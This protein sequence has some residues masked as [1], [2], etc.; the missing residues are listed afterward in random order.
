MKVLSVDDNTAFN[1]DMAA[2]LG[3][4][5]FDAEVAGS[6]EK[7]LSIIESGYQPDIVL[8]DIDL[9]KGRLDGAETA[10]IL[11][12]KYGIPVVF[13]SGHTDRDI[14]GK[15]RDAPGY[16]CIQKSFNN[17]YFIIENLRR[18]YRLHRRQRSRT[19]LWREGHRYRR[20]YLAAPVLFL[21][22]E[23]DHLI[24]SVNRP[25]GRFAGP[26]YE[27]T[28]GRRIGDAFRC[29][30]RLE[31]PRGCGFSPECPACGFYNLVRQ[32]LMNGDSSRK[33]VAV[34]PVQAGP[35]V[36][37]GKRHFSL[38]G[39]RVGENGS[40]RALMAVDETTPTLQ[41]Q[42]LSLL[43][44]MVCILSLDAKKLHYANKA[45]ADNWN[46]TAEQLYSNPLIWL[47][48][49][50]QDEKKNLL[51]FLKRA[52]ADVTGPPVRAR[53]V[54]SVP[55]GSSGSFRVLG[56]SLKGPDKEGR[57]VGLIFS[58]EDG[59]EG[60]MTDLHEE[61]ASLRKSA[62]EKTTLVREVHHRVKNNLVMIRSLINLKAR[63]LEK[64]Q[65]SIQDVLMGLRNQVTAIGTI[66]DKLYRSSDI[67]SIDVKDYLQD[68]LSS[69]FT[70]FADFKVKVIIDIP[71]VCTTA[72][73]ITP[74]GLMLNEMATN[75]LK[76]GFTGDSEPVFTLRMSRLPR[77]GR[78]RLDISNSGRP[79]PATVHLD[80]PATLGLRLILSMVE[81]LDGTITLSRSPIPHYILFLPGYHFSPMEEQ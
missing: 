32:C 8:M 50:E 59:R 9:G 35:G 1:M 63:S 17:D 27:V 57:V 42:L 79:F 36:P 24:K 45:F 18:A 70:S 30:N 11:K 29:L 2:L 21:E 12:D 56:Y 52:A 39:I 76:Y 41:D 51:G 43:E 5:G 72:D 20:L 53:I 49:L 37:E 10:K 75:A 54:L 40:S 47:D 13:L 55:G 16:G 73:T 66:H 31:D 26:G 6:G 3:K 74:L 58:K 15:I 80:N 48:S 22:V 28:K 64:E 44:D 77:E 71:P 69:I 7:C 25:A 23:E 46:A 81:Q 78:Y 38:V 67:M 33:S 65:E 4:N 60:A 61:I 68:L 14:I 62:D 19:K 34:L